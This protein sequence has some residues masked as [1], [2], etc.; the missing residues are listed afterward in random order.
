M[1][2]IRILRVHHKNSI[3]NGMYQSCTAGNMFD[4]DGAHPTPWKDIKL[5][6]G[7]WNG[8]MRWYFGFASVEQF[9]EWVHDP[10]WWKSL[11]EEGYVISV[12]EAAGII[13]DT[14]AV[15]DM[16][17]HKVIATAIIPEWFMLREHMEGY[18]NDAHSTA[19]PLAS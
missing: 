17:E 18:Q 13:G 11:H 8:G 15:V 3:R 1:R 14:Q 2:T 12:I 7:G 19:T 9:L 6:S 5:T 16:W 10:D 4:M